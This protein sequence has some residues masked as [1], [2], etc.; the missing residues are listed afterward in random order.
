VVVLVDSVITR[1]RIFSAFFGTAMIVGG[2][3]RERKGRAMAEAADPESEASATQSIP[4]SNTAPP[5]FF[6][7]IDS[8]KETIASG[9]RFHIPPGSNP[10]PTRFTFSGQRIN[11]VG[12]GPNVSLIVF[13]PASAQTA[14]EFNTPEPG[15][16]YQS[17]IRDIGFSSGNSINKTGILI[18][19]GAS[20]AVERIGIPDGAWPG[21]GSIGIRTR[22]RQQIR[23]RDCDIACARPIVVS[24]NRVFPTIAGDYTSIMASELISTSAKAA[25]I[26]VENGSILSNFVIRDTALVGG[27]D[28]F[29]LSTYG[30]QIGVNSNLQFENIRTEQGMDPD[31][32]SFNLESESDTLQSLYFCNLLLDSQRNGIRLRNAQRVTMVNVN[33][34]QADAKT[35]LDIVGVPGTVLTMIG[36]WGQV[37]GR[38]SLARL[39]KVTGLNSDV[40]SPIGPF[41]QWVYD[42]S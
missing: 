1:R 19:N 26:E 14:I 2:W 16:Q 21:S 5:D 39:R 41:E 34:N 28:A 29:R 35:L 15:G 32:W 3:M 33:I 31:G 12:D 22:G 4:T 25:V 24:P 18:D 7:R 36:C 30:P 11:L 40:G 13:N 20:I 23:I 10:L 17:S 37:G 42:G 9:G 8:M 38:L 27:R 6:S